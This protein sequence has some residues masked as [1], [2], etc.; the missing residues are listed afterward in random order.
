MRYERD[1]VGALSSEND[2]HQTFKAET[3]NT[4]SCNIWTRIFRGRRERR[5]S[6]TSSLKHTENINEKIEDA[7]RLLQDFELRSTIDQTNEL[8][9]LS[10]LACQ[11]SCTLILRNIPIDHEDQHIT[12]RLEALLGF[13]SLT[14]QE[15]PNSHLSDWFIHFRTAMEA[16]GAVV[17]TS[18]FNVGQGQIRNLEQVVDDNIDEVQLPRKKAKHSAESSPNERC[19]ICSDSLDGKYSRPCLKCKKGYCHECLV[20]QIDA[21]LSDIEHFPARCCGRVIHFDVAQGIISDTKLQRYKTLFEER[22]TTKPIYCANPTCS[23]FLPS[24]IAKP[25]SKGQVKCVQCDSTTCVECKV[26]VETANHTCTDADATKALLEQFEYKLCPRCNAGVAKMYGCSHMRCQC[27]AHFCWDCT[28]PISV[29]HNRPCIARAEEE[30][31]DYYSEEER[32]DDSDSDEET[33]SQ[34]VPT[35]AG[36]YIDITVADTSAEAQESATSVMHD[37]DVQQLS[38]PEIAAANEQVQPASEADGADASTSVHEVDTSILTVIGIPNQNDASVV[39]AEQAIAT[40]APRAMVEIV[41]LDAE[42]ADD[43]EGDFDFG[44]EPAD[45]GWDIWGCHHIFEP[46]HEERLW[47]GLDHW[48]PDMPDTSTGRI[49]KR[50]DCMRCYKPFVLPEPAKSSI[51]RKDSACDMTGTASKSSVDN[52]P[53]KALEKKEKSTKKAKKTNPGY[54]MFDCKCCGVVYC[55]GCHKKVLKEQKKL[56][57]AGGSH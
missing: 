12:Q 13:V 48:I 5:R 40:P 33:E 31:Y 26:V 38:E 4:M 11:N 50:V 57:A 37:S 24:R 36:Q 3:N 15:K 19:L 32:P 39:P 30:G 27:G 49:V 52:T 43:W 28:R 42:D 21:A 6:K 29:C 18:T 14:R 23:T 25:D 47:R 22:H 2:V 34:E 7:S 51:E 45:E 55:P 16:A 56:L 46:I 9:Y 54:K 8:F 35:S 41:N 1:N 10:N 17:S 20:N 53:R 44:Q